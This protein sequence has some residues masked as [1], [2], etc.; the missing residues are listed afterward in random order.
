MIIFLPGHTPVGRKKASPT[1]N[2]VT[3]ANGDI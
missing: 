1:N 2:M 3:G